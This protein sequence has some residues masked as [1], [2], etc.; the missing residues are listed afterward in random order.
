LMRKVLKSLD[1]PKTRKHP[2][3]S[4]ADDK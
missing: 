1:L 3:T 2:K 4:F